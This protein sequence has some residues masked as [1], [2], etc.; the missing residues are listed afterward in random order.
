MPSPDS[1]AE[2]D[3][4]VIREAANWLVRLH[5]GETAPA[6]H[7]AFERWRRANPDHER[8][9]QRAERLSAKFGAVSPALGVPVLTRQGHINRRAVLKTL[10]ILGAVVPAGW[11]GARLL[12]DKMEDVYSAAVGENRRIPLAD[13]S[14]VQLNTSTDIAVRYSDEARLLQ[15]RQGEIYIET[16]ADIRSPSRPFLVETR[17][18][19]LR[20]LGTRFVVRELSHGNRDVTALTVL[21][22]RV[23]I[24]LKSNGSRRIIGAGETALFSDQAFEAMEIQRQYADAPSWTKGMLQAD[25]MRLDA[26]LQELARYR[27]GIVRC[28]PQVAGLRVSGMFLLG[29]TDHILDIIGETLPVQVVRRTSYWVT[30]TSNV[31]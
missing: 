27:A 23:E 30:V 24:T 22:H 2:L 17:Q 15:L 8:A 11:L 25:N 16:A 29:D 3:P 6:D 1:T 28:D 18:G 13:R 12:R 9:W 14:L 20:A 10:A 31:Q 26:F 21:E 4:A 7:E 19:T 5:S